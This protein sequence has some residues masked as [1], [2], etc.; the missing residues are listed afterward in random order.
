VIDTGPTTRSRLAD[1]I[2]AVLRHGVDERVF[3]GAAAAVAIGKDRCFVAA[4][5]E[6]YDPSAPE[7]DAHAIFDVASLTKV[8]ATT[9]AIMQLIEVDALSLDDR[10]A[11]FLPKLDQS[12]KRD[13]TIR[14]LMTHTAGFPGPYEFYRFCRSPEELVEAIYRVDLVYPVGG[15]RLYDDIGFM[16]L[17]FIVETLTDTRF[18][19]YCA[20]HIFDPLQ[21]TET[22]FLPQAGD[23][24]IIPTEIDPNRGGLLRGVVHDEN[25]FVLGGVAGHAGLFSR[26]F[27]LLR[28]ASLMAG[29]KDQ[30]FEILS[31]ET[32]RR[33]RNC[34]WRDQEGEY[35]LGWD[36]I[37]PHYMG[38]IDDADAIGHTGFTGT[39]IVISPRR[40]LAIVL[41]SNRVHPQRSDPAAINLVRRTLVQ[42]V[43]R[44][45]A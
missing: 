14:H 36:R 31:D 12:G 29:A 7:T 37:R 8:V 32:I 5:R 24:Q 25:T 33:V 39:S 9:T 40:A 35:G 22:C 45:C 16:L 42:T 15:K 11:R 26:T 19:Q 2:T 20:Q 21:M 6:T 38:A 43:L 10:A 3:P 28:F 44:H 13:I 34:E 23:E 18:D 17:A 4:G 27:D 30:R 41:L 1:D